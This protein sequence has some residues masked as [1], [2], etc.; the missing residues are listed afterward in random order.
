VVC[1]A[2]ATLV[3]ADTAGAR[4]SFTAYVATALVVVAGGL[5]VG[6]WF[7]RAR[8]LIAVGII[9]SVVLSIGY[10]GE[11]VS[12]YTTDV[13]RHVTWTPTTI[14]ALGE[15]YELRAGQATLDLTSIDFT[16]R[17]TTLSAKIGVGDLRIV[18]PPNVDV[19]LDA[20]VGAGDARLF[21]EN[22]D[23]LGVERSMSDVGVD[24]P[25]GGSLNLTTEVGVGSLEVTR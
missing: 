18:L 5:V 7:G 9:L 13:D 11:K 23:G 4:V 3:I 14:A 22:V 16:D 25:G 10:A 20:K 24:G 17:T 6:A 12:D 19:Q 21:E 8:L 2:L 15:N 1:L